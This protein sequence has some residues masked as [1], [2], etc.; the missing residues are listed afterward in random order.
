MRLTLP[1]A[2][3]GD[4]L[5]GRE[6]SEMKREETAVWENRRYLIIHRTGSFHG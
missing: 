5:A 1:A 3:A 4:I 2:A 6:S